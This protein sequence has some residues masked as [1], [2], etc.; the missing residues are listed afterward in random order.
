MSKLKKLMSTPIKS[1]YLTS[2]LLVILIIAYI[3]VDTKYVPRLVSQQPPV[4]KLSISTITVTTISRTTTTFTNNVTPQENLLDRGDVLHKLESVQIAK[5][6]LIKKFKNNRSPETDSALRTFID[7]HSKIVED[8]KTD[9]SSRPEY[10]TVLD[11]THGLSEALPEESL[12]KYH[13]TW[14]VLQKYKDCGI[15][16]EGLAEGMGWGLQQDNDYIIQ[17]AR[18]FKSN[19]SEFVVFYFDETRYSLGMDASLNLA[20]DDLRKKI[21]RFETF[22]RQH[23]QLSEVE[24][25][26][27]PMIN[28]MLSFYIE[29]MDNTPAYHGGTGKID[30][31]LETSYVTFLNEDKN[32][33]YFSL[34]QGVFN[35]LKEHDFRLNKSLVAF[36]HS[37]K[38]EAFNGTSVREFL[39]KT[40]F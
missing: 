23:K 11:E 39:E 21:I 30:E 24:T 22:A 32:S 29:G 13:D 38:I 27:K 10:Q 1:I 40:S 19:Y 34:I 25:H 26:I 16:F 37:Q 7:F 18:E 6:D 8:L 36:V 33:E 17:L 35:N 3:K 15:G 4:Q 14:Q 2:A 9:F 28:N 12:E 31:E 5:A 20:W